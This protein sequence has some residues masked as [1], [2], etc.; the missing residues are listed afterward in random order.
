M[1]AAALAVAVDE[2]RDAA[3]RAALLE[4][5][6]KAM[7][8]EDLILTWRR[9]YHRLELSWGHLV[10][11]LREVRQALRSRFTTR[12]VPHRFLCIWSP[13]GSPR[14]LHMYH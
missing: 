14:R 11:A 8:H 4:L 10:D 7:C 3:H 1:A 13:R 5:E 9:A 2:S 6:Y 12:E